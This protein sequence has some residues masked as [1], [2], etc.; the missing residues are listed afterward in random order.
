MKISKESKEYKGVSVLEKMLAKRDELSQLQADT[1]TTANFTGSKITSKQKDGTIKSYA[2]SNKHSN[3][4]DIFR[5]EGQSALPAENTVNFDFMPYILAAKKVAPGTIFLIDNDV[6]VLLELIKLVRET[7]TCSVKIGVLFRLSGHTTPFCIEKIV[8]ED[9]E[10][11]SSSMGSNSMEKVVVYHTDSVVMDI[12]QGDEIKEV[13]KQIS[14]VVP[15]YSLGYY[16][17]DQTILRDYKRQSDE[18]SCATYTLFD[19]EEIIQMNF[20]QFAKENSNEYSDNLF[21]LNKLPSIFMATIQSIE[22]SKEGGT[23]VRNGLKHFIKENPRDSVQ[24]IIING[25][26]TSLRKIYKELQEEGISNPI[27]QIINQY[28]YELYKNA[29]TSKE[30]CLVDY[31]LTTH[32]HQ[33][34]ESKIKLANQIFDVARDQYENKPSEQKGVIVKAVV[35]TAVV[36]II[37]LIVHGLLE[38]QTRNKSSND[39]DTGRNSPSTSAEEDSVHKISDIH[40]KNPQKYLR[41]KSEGIQYDEVDDISVTEMVNSAFGQGS[42]TARLIKER[43]QIMLGRDIK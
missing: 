5:F 15:I 37:G 28:Y 9:D 13:V 3:E 42:F 4:K 17:P 16:D 41:K 12:D 22:G 7:D 14:K 26:K 39:K 31:M 11:S 27:I 10:L 40:N 2:K 32:H 18:Y 24:T 30:E 36:V 38:S 21:I 35:I 6:D 43:Q 33:D 34:E 23:V 20:Y 8:P 25:E 29:T 19:V 1:V